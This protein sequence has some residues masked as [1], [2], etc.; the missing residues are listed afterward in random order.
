MELMIKRLP[1]AEFTVMKAIW[2]SETPVTTTVIN[3]QL[4]ADVSWKPQTLLTLLA[5]LAEKGLLKSERKGRERCYT[6]LISE[7][8]YLKI[9]TG[10]FL[11]RYSD[12][13]IGQLV[14]ALCA[15]TD[16]SSED[17]NELKEW[18]SRKGRA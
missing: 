16:L 7:E 18:L 8:E 3:E 6:P 4:S 5:R 11:S 1:D 2:N 10:N 12:N 13:S 15:E 14:K 17:I 9:E